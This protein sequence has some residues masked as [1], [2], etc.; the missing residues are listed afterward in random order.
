MKKI[1]IFTLTSM[2][3]ATFTVTAGLTFLLNHNATITNSS[4]N[5]ESKKD[6]EEMSIVTDDTPLNLLD[7][8]FLGPDGKTKTKQASNYER[9][10]NS[11]M[12]EEISWSYN[13]NATP[14]INFADKENYFVMELEDF[15]VGQVL[16]FDI[17]NYN[18]N[19][20]LVYQHSVVNVTATEHFETTKPMKIYHPP[21]YSNNG[22]GRNVPIYIVAD[23]TENK[24]YVWYAIYEEDEVTFNNEDWDKVPITTYDGFNVRLDNIV[25]K[26][27]YSDD[28][29]NDLY[30]STRF[31]YEDYGK[32]GKLFI[33]YSAWPNNIQNNITSVWINKTGDT[34][35]VFEFNTTD[36]LVEH[37]VTN[38]T[39]SFNIDESV[40]MAAG[41]NE[42]Y[43]VG[44]EVTNGMYDANGAETK[45]SLGYIQE[46]D[47][48]TGYGDYFNWYNNSTAGAEI[49][50][51]SN[52]DSDSATI[53]LDVAAIEDNSNSELESVYLKEGDI[54][55][56]DILSNGSF[57]DVEERNYITFNATNLENKKTYT[58]EYSFTTKSGTPQVVS[59]DFET[60]VFRTADNDTYI[61]EVLNYNS[62]KNNEELIIEVDILDNIDSEISSISVLGNKYDVNGP[63]VTSDENSLSVTFTIKDNFIPGS[64]FSDIE[65]YY[66]I[67]QFGDEIGVPSEVK[68]KNKNPVKI[69]GVFS[70]PSNDTYNVTLDEAYTDKVI[71]TVI[72]DITNDYTDSEM[73]Q[74]A[75]EIDGALF[76]KKFRI[77]SDEVDIVSQED[78][79][80][81]FRINYNFPLGE[82]IDAIYIY[83]SDQNSNE[84]SSPI[85]KSVIPTTITEE[86]II[87][88]ENTYT[89]SAT[90][91]TETRLEFQIKEQQ[92]TDSTIEAV[93]VGGIRYEKGDTGVSITKRGDTNT[94][95]IVGNF[96]K[97][98]SL[99]GI[100]IYQTLDVLGTISGAGISLSF[101]Q[102]IIGQA[103]VKADHSTYDV[104]ITSAY[105]EEVIVGV[106]DNLSSDSEILQIGFDNGQIYDVYSSNVKIA[107]NGGEI[108]YIISDNFTLNSKIEKVYLYYT[109]D[110]S[111]IPSNVPLEYTVSVTIGYEFTIPDVNTY[112]AEILNAYIDRVVFRIE[113]IVNVDAIISS[114]E[115]LGRKYQVESSL[116]TTKV[117]GNTTTYTIKDDFFDL[118]GNDITDIK[119]YYTEDIAG[120]E[121]STPIDITLSNSDSI[122]S[123]FFVANASTYSAEIDTINSS[124]GGTPHA[125]EDQ[126][127]INI[128]K[129]NLQITSEITS[130]I[131]GGNTFDV[132]SNEVE[133]KDVG[134]YVSYT[135]TPSTPFQAGVQYDYIEVKYTTDWSGTV[136]NNRLR[137]DLE[138]PFTIAKNFESIESKDDLK[139]QITEA[140]DTS[141]VLQVIETEDRVNTDSELTELIFNDKIKYSLEYE[142]IA[143]E[144]SFVDNSIVSVVE[145]TYENTADRDLDGNDM[146]TITI[147]D[148]NVTESLYPGVKDNFKPLTWIND[149]SVR[150][151]EDYY[152][153]ESEI[154]N[155]D[156]TPK[157]LEDVFISS[158]QDTWNATV[159]E[160][161]VEKISFKTTLNDLT[162]NSK[163]AQ[164]S[165]NFSDG[166]NKSYVVPDGSGNDQDKDKVTQSN[167]NGTDTKYTIVDSFPSGKELVSV[168]IIYTID[169]QG[170]ISSTPWT[171]DFTNNFIVFETLDSDAINKDSINFDKVDDE[172]IIVDITYDQSK[173][174]TSQ[175]IGIMINNKL[176]FIDPETPQNYSLELTS[177]S[178]ST[179]KYTLKN[180]KD[181]NGNNY[182]NENEDIK[183]YGVI[184][185]SSNMANSQGGYSVKSYNFKTEDW[186]NIPSASNANGLTPGILALISIGSVLALF[187]IFFLLLKIKGSLFSK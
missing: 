55:I 15:E 176:Y 48:N 117:N 65:I 40:L 147:R 133:Y 62:E 124:N 95:S 93:N 100:I 90:N 73:L 13:R 1:G 74:F 151:T 153:T 120:N 131:L 30:D 111:G 45:T 138:T 102:V 29:L 23:A 87:A 69:K 42:T 7:S 54:L 64:I 146:V 63:N 80:S 91:Y 27:N 24:L 181:N 47:S 66:T 128:T 26:N 44:V 34:Q 104:E 21:K 183:S 89:A 113:E 97:G 139:A 105:T 76:S 118:K 79:K 38:K 179:N 67:N 86:F 159:I 32:T 174:N 171:V 155:L 173:M 68:L 81:T 180:G 165:I 125:W 70:L 115:F 129:N 39:Y 123:E 16:R 58:V 51:I 75:V 152:G 101:P 37:D 167:L 50:D 148:N 92:P 20:D 88:D 135:I 109:T 160:A 43:K 2:I 144:K 158:T 169:K 107:N 141:I 172:K 8:Y 49:I 164:F 127:T 156:I 186:I 185:S 162:V 106:K 94:I 83:Y 122:N 35:R 110:P 17:W 145:S 41:Q 157:K 4:K 187:G 119:I 46:K 18:K 137:I 168:D 178:G 12:S 134:A 84:S 59:R 72:E 77:N 114:I 177:K 57:D 28:P 71:F 103:F 132:N 22:T 11:T 78:N 36:P 150:Y 126:V 161:N 99:S 85:I 108:S 163:I 98:T 25:V 140:T 175:I 130:I 53:T 143:G 182:W 170:N 166:S 19:N 9:P 116:V 154:K 6:I 82:T 60:Y 52:I 136:S 149:L 31:Y 3:F 5:E 121:S 184:Y 10:N 56:D 14:Y 142:M 112:K 96:K 61:A 33:D